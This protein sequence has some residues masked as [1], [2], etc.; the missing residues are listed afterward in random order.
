MKIVAPFE[1]VEF[2]K[3]YVTEFFKYAGCVVADEG[4]ILTV[5][6]SPELAAYFGKTTLRLVFQPEHLE[7]QTEL[8]TH[9]SYLANRIYDLLKPTGAKV[10]VLLPKRVVEA[11]DFRSLK[12]FGSL[13]FLPLQGLD[14]TLTARPAKEIRRTESY[15]I[16]RLT[17]SSDEKVEELITVKSDF[18]GNLQVMSAFPHFF[19]GLQGAVGCRFPLTRKQAKAIYDRCLAPVERYAEQQAHARQGKFAPHFHENAARLEAYYRQMIDEVPV[20]EPGRE[21]V[22]RQLQDEYEL[23]I[24]EELK[25]CQIQAAITPISFCT[26]TIPFRQ[27]RYTL[28]TDGGRKKTNTAPP[29]PKITFDVYHNLFSGEVVY[30]PC[31]SCGH[32]LKQ[33]GV[34]EMSGHPVC[35]DCLHECR[36]CAEEEQ[37]REGATAQRR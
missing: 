32:G 33:I 22:I 4:N 26:L 34:C 3:A 28:E 2:M 10:S 8:V 24:T 13:P 37:N 12:D 23:K 14:C 27:Y 15:L 20:L 21:L 35:Q 7:P 11:Q 6:L 18:M 36:A 1:H 9:G 5:E 19:S 16:F 25:K 30:P 17:Y 29:A 31:P